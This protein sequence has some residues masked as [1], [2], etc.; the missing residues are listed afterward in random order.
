VEAL[1]S[2]GRIRHL[3]SL[4]GSSV[5]I[6]TEEPRQVPPT[7]AGPPVSEILIAQRRGEL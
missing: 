4:V 1:V 2:T 6:D 3:T 7:I 5:D